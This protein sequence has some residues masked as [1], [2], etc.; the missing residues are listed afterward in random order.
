[1]LIKF[2]FKKH[3]LI[4]TGVVFLFV[5]LGFF[6]NGIMRSFPKHPAM[7]TP[8]FF[9]K[10]IDR[11]DLK[12]RV[13]AT[14]ELN[15]LVA[16]NF[17][18]EFS[19]ID[20]SGA[21]LYPP[22]AELPFDWSKI[23]L[24]YGAYESVSVDE[25]RQP[26]FMP[27]P[28]HLGR[29][30]GPPRKIVRLR[31]I[32]A[33]NIFIDFDKTF[34]PKPPLSGLLFSIGSLVGS[35]LIGV[36]LSFLLLFRTLN[37]QIRSA[38]FVLGELQRGNLK[39]R[40]PVKRMDEIGQAMNRFNLMAD[41]IERLVERLRNT[42]SAR[43]NLLQEL[44]HDLRTPIASLRTMLDTISTKHQT[45]TE[46]LHAELIGLA[47]KEVGYFER[48]VEDLLVLALADEPRY[49]A[50]QQEVPIIDLLDTETDGIVQQQQFVGKNI[51]VSKDFPA[52]D[53]EIFGNDHL[54][55]RMFRNALE[56]AFSFAKSE[57]T[58]SASVTSDAEI[59][60]T[61]CDD[62]PGMS[63]DVIKSYGTR[64][65]TRSI[66]TSGAGRVSIGLGSVILKTIAGLH[67]GSVHVCNR[68]DGV[69]LVVGASVTIT[70]PL[71]CRLSLER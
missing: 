70:L 27:G 31:G 68:L 18:L 40:F 21:V 49:R 48:L 56:N 11:L 25:K 67:G 51:R 7:E 37:R 28:P 44:A 30:P 53:I 23:K 35:I 33:Q 54:L 59:S 62:G 5:V 26:K 41:E 61:I 64:R 4:T 29:P 14:K 20:G 66:E 6:F 12:N 45:M 36:G 69:G 52:H 50:S 8:D 22:G 17:P 15:E 24:P 71:G 63:G 19:L 46:E 38:D 34:M 47:Q 42:E 65:I 9:A 3:Y 1:M 39:A 57:V 43:M 13:N 10:I 32:P 58:V 2:L 55:C 60:I 16:G